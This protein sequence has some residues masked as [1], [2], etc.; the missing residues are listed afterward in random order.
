MHFGA[1]ASSVARLISATKIS[2]IVFLLLVT[3]NFGHCS[4]AISALYAIARLYTVD[5]F[6]RKSF[7]STQIS[8]RD[9]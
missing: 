7:I 8:K 4:G 9:F 6:D 2:V 1:T 3:E 5:K